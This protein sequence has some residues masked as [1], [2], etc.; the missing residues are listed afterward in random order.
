MAP[1]STIGGKG[2]ERIGAV[3]PPAGL[4]PISQDVLLP[5]FSTF[6]RS[7]ESLLGILRDMTL[8]SRARLSGGKY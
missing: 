7:S 4:T 6:M 3:I 8:F 1:S 5:L 2:R